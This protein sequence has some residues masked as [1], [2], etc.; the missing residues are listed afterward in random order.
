MKFLQG[1]LILSTLFTHTF[2]SAQEFQ[3]ETVVQRGHLQPVSVMAWHPSGNFF[4]TGSEDQ[5]IILWDAKTGKQIRNFNFHTGKVLQLQ[6]SNDG[7]ELLS[8]GDDLWVYATN[9]YTGEINFSYHYKRQNAYPMSV[10]YSSQE[11][12]ILIGDNSDQ[13]LVIDK[14]SKK[15]TT[16][17]KG[18]SA[19]IHRLSLS[20]DGKSAVEVIDY[21]SLAVINLQNND[22]ILIEFDKPN[23]Y[24]FSPN[25][26]F[27]AVGSDKLFGKIFDLSNGKEV[28]HFESEK[29]CD[30]CKYRMTW[31]HDGKYL[32]TYNHYTGLNLINSSNGKTIFQLTFD[33]KRFNSLVFTKDN[34]NVFLKNE[35]EAIV[36]DIKKKKAIQILENKHGNVHPEISPNGREILLPDQYFTIGSYQVSNGR[37]NN[38][39]K[40]FFNQPEEL[41][42]DI[43][44]NSWFNKNI[45]NH[46]RMKPSI[47]ISSDERYIA[48]GKTDT[49][50]AVFDLQTGRHLPLLKGHHEKVMSVAFHPKDEIMATGDANGKVIIWDL[51]NKKIIDQFRA[52]TNVVFDLDFNSDGSELLSSGWDAMIKHWKIGDDRELIGYFDLKNLSAY[53]VGFSPG[54]LYFIV[55]DVADNLTLYETDSKKEVRKWIGHTNTISDFVVFN[56][57]N[58]N[59]LMATVSRDGSVKIWDYLSGIMVGK[60]YTE[61]KSAALS[62]AFHPE[63]NQ[64]LMGA[65]D[66]KIYVFDIDKK[67][68]VQQFK[69]HNAGVNFLEIH[70]QTLYSKSIDGEVK[71]WSLNNNTPLEK[72]AYYQM[73]SKD[74][75]ISHPD[76]YFDGTKNAMEQINYVKGLQ[77]LEVGTFF[78]KFQ[79]PNLYDAIKRGDFEHQNDQGIRQFMDT[80]LPDYEF[81]FKTFQEQWTRVVNDSTYQH[82]SS[83]ISMELRMNDKISV[84]DDVSIYNNGKLTS[85]YK[86]NEELAFRGFGKKIA[87][88]THLIPGKNHLEVN[89][90]TIDGLSTS[91]QFLE[92]YFDTLGGQTE[93]FVLSLGINQYENPN[94]NLKYAGND[95]KSFNKAIESGAKEL[96]HKVYSFHLEDKKVTKQRVHEELEKIKAQMG[97]EDV[98]VFYY[99]GHGMMFNN[100]DNSSDFYLIMSDITNLYGEKKMLDQKGISAKELLEIS[101]NLPAQKQVFVLD[102]CQSGAALKD[103]AIRGVER[104]KTLARLARNTGTFFLTAAQDAEF[105]NEVGALEHGVFTYAILELLEGSTA[106]KNND[107]TISIYELKSYVETRVPELSREHKGSPQYPTGYSFGNDFP[108]GVVK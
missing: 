28:Y 75:L 91:P 48:Q 90:T 52:H 8:S 96:F 94:Y 6:F 60:F 26:K 21:K 24:S 12:Y 63:K 73:T 86:P 93:L 4:A 92:I 34:S 88:E 64:L 62:V 7:K 100:E 68:I 11:N 61:N 98:F 36:I 74:W 3:I 80:E 85:N 16:F 71:I 43:D 79:Y 108:I 40:G 105:A 39:Y 58:E 53:K 82:H 101:K 55:G 25:G 65:A 59:L 18:Y 41:I 47:A 87:L 14:T 99:A 13:L 83:N 106:L 30:G 44:Y 45:V 22:S 17:K 66:R 57:R 27:L 29:K 77:S 37:K 102:A 78:K 72:M 56:D 84:I 33:E 95:A 51:K 31:S 49:S 46:I 35:E 1:I 50:V 67:E 10:S 5:S 38:H 42:K 20:P 70:Q 15:T 103:L 9:I 76:G 23:N 107:E 81:Y 54:D 89:L 32:A 2:S 69:A 104:E 19:A 97:P